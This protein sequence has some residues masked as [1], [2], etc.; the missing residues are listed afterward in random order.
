MRSCLRLSKFMRLRDYR[1]SRLQV[2]IVQLTQIG[3]IGFV[4]DVHGGTLQLFLH[5]ALRAPQCFEFVYVDGV[6]RVSAL[7]GARL[8]R[9]PA[10]FRQRLDRIDHI[11]L[12]EQSFVRQSLDAR[13]SITRVSVSTCCAHGAFVATRATRSAL[14]S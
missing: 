3:E 13:P 4:R 10:I 12:A 9:H 1:R 7:Y 5:L 11:T 14:S 8:N 6:R 2:V